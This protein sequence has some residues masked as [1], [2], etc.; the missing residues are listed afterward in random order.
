M[1]PRVWHV[2]WSKPGS[3]Y[4]CTKLELNW[5]SHSR[6]TLRKRLRKQKLTYSISAMTSQ[7]NDMTQSANF[8]AKPSGNEWMKGMWSGSTLVQQKV[9]IIAKWSHLDKIIFRAI[10]ENSTCNFQKNNFLLFSRSDSNSSWKTGSDEWN[11]LLNTK[12]QIL[13]WNVREIIPWSQTLS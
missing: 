12:S 11:W 9:V 6:F 3:P 10:L 5:P 7:V 8:H 13:T 4:P 1:T 2:H